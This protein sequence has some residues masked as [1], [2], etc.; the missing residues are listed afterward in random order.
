MPNIRHMVLIEAPAEAVYR[1]VTNQESLSGWWTPEVSAVPVLHGIARFGFG[2]DYFKEMRITTLHP[3]KLVRWDCI[4]AVEEWVGTT[5][6]FEIES[7]SRD[8]L[9]RSHPEADDQIR[10]S[11]G[12]TLSLLAFSQDDWRDYTPMFAECNYTWGRFLRSLKALCETGK[13]WPWPHQHGAEG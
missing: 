7:G 4:T 9:L 5:I 8:E 13:G 3:P 1:A 6:S 12:H 11:G 2:P 10:Q